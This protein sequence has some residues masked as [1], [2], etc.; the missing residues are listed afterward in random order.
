M[1]NDILDSI[2][3]PN[4]RIERDYARDD[5]IFTNLNN[6]KSARLDRFELENSKLPV[7]IISDIIN[8]IM[9]WD[10]TM[11]GSGGG[12]QHIV[13][14]GGG[15]IGATGMPYYLDDPHEIDLKTKLFS[16]AEQM[17]IA[18]V[19]NSIRKHFI[20]NFGGWKF[21]MEKIVIA[22][23]CFAS[24]INREP[25]NDYDVFMLDDDSNRMT[26]ES[27][28]VSPLSGDVR[29]GDSNYMQNDK[30]EKTVFVKNSRI[31]YIN[32]KYKTRE[33]LIKHF[34]FK[35]CCVSYDFSKDKLYIT[36]EV[37]DLIKAKKLVHNS[38]KP[39]ALWRYEKFHD[40]GWKSDP[41]IV[42][43]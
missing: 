6:H 3:I 2:Q 35:H 23:G 34:D 13:N 39:P 27:I 15:A 20:E 7:S 14:G 28:S 11:Q 40:R 12:I 4:L 9:P 26:V 19:K 41:V 38:D 17:L 33:E 24:M 8:Q 21:N 32:T 18:D 31:Q 25:V 1:M 36:R 16:Y 30:I 5:I 10:H 42:A 29:V 37:Y 43:A 22:G